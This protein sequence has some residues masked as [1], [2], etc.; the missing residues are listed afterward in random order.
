MDI[1]VSFPGNKEGATALEELNVALDQLDIP[2]LAQLEYPGKTAAQIRQISS[3][4]RSEEATRLEQAEMWGR[5]ARLGGDVKFKHEQERADLRAVAQWFETTAKP[6]VAQAS[7]IETATVWMTGKGILALVGER[8]PKL[9]S[10]LD[11]PSDYRW[12][13]DLNLRKQNLKRK[14]G[15]IYD[16]HGLLEQLR[17]SGDFWGD[18]PPP[19][20]GPPKP[21]PTNSTKL[22]A[23]LAVANGISQKSR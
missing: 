9:C 22:Y 7:K 16:Y 11:S 4:K 2:L 15:W 18:I 21:D 23:Q 10:I 6:Q 1:T 5:V 13:D 12:L 3:R 14:N 19:H 8:S 17:N 20:Q